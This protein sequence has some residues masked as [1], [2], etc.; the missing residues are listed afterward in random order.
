MQPNY[1]QNHFFS[2]SI[3]GKKLIIPCNSGLLKK[4][5]DPSWNKLNGQ[6][7]IVNN[8]FPNLFRSNNHIFFS[9][10]LN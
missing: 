1:H 6:Q 10:K 7:L 2:F 5:M 3:F 4:N 9:T 8:K